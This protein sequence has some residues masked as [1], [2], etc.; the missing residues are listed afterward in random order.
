MDGPRECH[1]EGS[2]P[3][4]EREISYDIPNMWTLKNNDT[5]ELTYRTETHRLRKRT[6]GCR[7]KGIV[8]D[9]GKDMYTLLYLKCITN[10]DLLYNTWNSAQC[11]GTGVGFRGEW[12]HVYVWLSP[13]T[14]HLKLSQHC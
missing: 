12:I 11:N 10:K 7:G 14:V 13:S 3:D 4:R 6:H 8:K 5:N 1:T 2:K 9:F